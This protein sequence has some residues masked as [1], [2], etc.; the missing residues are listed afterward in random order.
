VFIDYNQN[1]GHVGRA[2]GRRDLRELLD[3][4]ERE[5]R[6]GVGEPTVM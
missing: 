2:A 6:E 3:W 5:E 4:V 1:A